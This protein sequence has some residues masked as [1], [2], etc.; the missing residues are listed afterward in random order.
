MTMA[1]RTMP[2]VRITDYLASSGY[3]A[4]P[5]ALVLFDAQ[6]EGSAFHTLYTYIQ[7]LMN[8]RHSYR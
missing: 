4:N 3:F 8:T 1:D 5:K 2:M 6:E 7:V